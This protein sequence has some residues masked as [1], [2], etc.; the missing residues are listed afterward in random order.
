MSA[1][2]FFASQILLQ[3]VQLQI[4]F[5]YSWC[6]PAL[7]V[8]ILIVFSILTSNSP[9]CCFIHFFL[10]IDPFICSFICSSVLGQFSR[11][12]TWHKDVLFKWLFVGVLSEEEKA[13]NQVKAGKK[14]KHGY[15]SLGDLLWS[16]P[17][18]IFY[19]TNC[20][21]DLVQLFGNYSTLFNHWPRFE[22]WKA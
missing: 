9:K 21:I 10:S 4:Q 6:N 14:S 7:L 18:G 5:Q 19:S 11:S 15:D 22:I 20:T 2:D 3:I 16:D 17:W 12:G 1:F 13:N 8:L